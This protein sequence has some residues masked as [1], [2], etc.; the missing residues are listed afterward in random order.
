MWPRGAFAGLNRFCP[1]GDFPGLGASRQ[2]RATGLSPFGAHDVTRILL[3]RPNWPRSRYR[4]VVTHSHWKFVGSLGQVS[5]DCD[6]QAP[7]RPNTAQAWPKLA[8]LHGL[9]LHV[10]Q[11]VASGIAGGFRP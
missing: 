3:F 4:G 9:V 5:P 6:R 7:R 1:S 8:F 2:P 10:P 11:W